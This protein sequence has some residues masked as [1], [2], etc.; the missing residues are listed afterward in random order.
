VFEGWIGLQIGLPGTPSFGLPSSSTGIPACAPIPRGT[1]HPMLGY[2]R[3]VV[4]F[5]VVSAVAPVY[6]EA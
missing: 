3:D 6:P 1:C 2:P 5:Y 4:P